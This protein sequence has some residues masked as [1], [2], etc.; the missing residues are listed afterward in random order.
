MSAPEQIQLCFVLTNGAPESLF[1]YP[2]PE[3]ATDSKALA[4]LADCGF[5]GS[6][7]VDPR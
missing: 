3:P 2:D 6:K 5:C 1:R 7:S 4:D